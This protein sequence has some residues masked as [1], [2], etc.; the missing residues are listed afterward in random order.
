MKHKV[1][2]LIY[3]GFGMGA[4]I[5][6]NEIGDCYV[7]WYCKEAPALRTKFKYHEITKMRLALLENTDGRA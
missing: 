3:G 5:R 7:E 1:G 4:I 2:D 6:I